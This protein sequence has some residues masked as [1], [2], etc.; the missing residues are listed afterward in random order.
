MSTEA[1]TGL[2]TSIANAIRSKSGT[3]SSLM[4]R[5]MGNVIRSIKN[6]PQTPQQG[7]LNGIFQ[8]MADA[9]RACG[10]AGTMTPMQIP[11]KVLQIPT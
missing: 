1:L 5:E 6:V 8:D 7:T 9:I 10:V 4:P 3:S 2:F 11:D